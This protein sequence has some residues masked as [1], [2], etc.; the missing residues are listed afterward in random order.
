MVLK[1]PER[2]LSRPSILF[3]ITKGVEIVKG[4]VIGPTYDL[5]VNDVPA[6]YDYGLREV[7]VSA[8]IAP[9]ITIVDVIRAV[10]NREPEM[11]LLVGIGSSQGDEST[12][13]R[14]YAKSLVTRHLI[15]DAAAGT[16]VI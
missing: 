14:L 11:S 15:V 1:S 6:R 5:S 10:P 8:P 2:S 9:D 13:G 12:V 16:K 4:C 7:H 3:L